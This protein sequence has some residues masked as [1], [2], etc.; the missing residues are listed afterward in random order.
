MTETFREHVQTLL[1]RYE[2]A[3]RILGTADAVLVHSGTENHYYADDQ[4]TPFR[5]FGHFLH[6]LPVARPGQLL[7]IEPGRKPVYFQYVPRDYWYDQA[8][9]IEEWWAR[10]FEIVVLDQADGAKDFLR[11]RPRLAFIGE[12][13]GAA[14]A[15]GIE[16]SMVNPAPLLA[17]LDFHRACKSEYEIEQLRAANH[18]ALRGHT[19]A[20]DCFLA[21]GSELDI[22]ARYLQ[23]CRISELDTPYNNIVAINEKSAIL[24]Y[25]NKRTQDEIAGKGHVLLIDAGCRINGYCSDITRTTTSPDCHPLFVS[26][27]TEVD[28]LKRQLVGRVRPDMD[29]A[30]LQREAM[31]ALAGILRRHDLAYG[32]EE[33]LLALRIPHLFMP[34]GVGHLLGLQVHDVGGHLASPTGERKPPPPEFPYLRNTRTLV[35]DMVFTVEPGL[36]FIPMLLDPERDT[37]RGRLLNWTLVDALVP[38][39]GTR[40]EDNVRVTRGGV[41]NL[42][43]IG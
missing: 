29:Y 25:Q 35:E 19:A 5:A 12:H 3:L 27:V 40:S 24:H 7:L 15:L 31:A 28:R 17:W 34:H 26:L 10:E 39:G 8:L 42:T 32:S 6:W 23:A 33:E 38:Y 11:D 18:L 36:Y 2:Q 30:D 16:P 41:E 14:R 1:T 4:A 37:P 20:A 9:A 22:H 13:H 43:S 21:G